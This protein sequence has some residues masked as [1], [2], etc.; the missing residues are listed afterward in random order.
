MSNKIILLDEHTINQIAAGEVIEAPLSVVKELVE[1]SMDA[2]A[3]SIYVGIKNGGLDEIVVVD[4]GLGIS[5][6]D[7]PKAFLRHGT[8]K[9]ATIDDL[10]QLETMGFRGEALP[11]IAAVSDLTIVTSTGKECYSFGM[12]GDEKK[13]LT[14]AS[15]N[16]GTKII[17][18]DL[19]FNAPVRQKFL[20]S[21]LKEAKQ[22]VKMVENLALSRTDIAFEMVVDGQESFRTRG[23]G[24]VRDALGALYSL[25]TV[26][27]M[28]EFSVIDNS[29]AITGLLGSYQQYRGSREYQHF[30]INK[31]Y[32][33]SKELSRALERAY[34][35]LIPHKKF[36]LAVIYLTIPTYEIEVNIHP[37]K[38]EVKIENSGAIEEFLTE[39]VRSSLYEKKVEPKVVLEEK[40]EIVVKKIEVEKVAEDKKGFSYTFLPP[41]LGT[42]ITPQRDETPIIPKQ[43]TLSNDGEVDTLNPFKDIEPLG[44]VDQTYILGI[45]ESKL[46]IFDQHAAH[47]RI[48]FEKKK[49][50]FQ[51]VGYRSQNLILPVT[52]E[53]SSSDYL[54]IIDQIVALKDY[55]VLLEVFGKRSFVVRQLP[56]GIE[57]SIVGA[58][59]VLDLLDKLQENKGH[60]VEEYL[61]EKAACSASVK[62]HQELSKHEMKELL[63]LLGTCSFPYTC[64]HGR[65]T[66]IEQSKEA[67]AK[68]FLRGR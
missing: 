19:F 34:L 2:G 37:K 64:P 42:K 54:K 24:Q 45:K 10:Y 39:S 21:P 20:K 46:Y 23:T 44:Q 29:V 41:T 4:N 7:L 27:Q 40:E 9:L 16:R 17:V 68:M 1:N 61:I 57:G 43:M 30:F 8:S 51:E 63:K 59:F 47:E 22:V 15:G 31:R 6:E 13:E 58:N 55:G 26:A 67:L 48:N 33:K 25:E 28:K 65:P 3:T 18:R 38:L 66:V 62:A 53:V 56:L 14:V 32:V 11:S 35:N 12:K 49:K 36:P 60:E 50:E 52:L 5:K